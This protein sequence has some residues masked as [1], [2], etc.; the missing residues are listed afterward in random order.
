MEPGQS[1]SLNNNNHNKS[2]P[3]AEP[4]YLFYSK[5]KVSKQPSLS[6]K[7]EG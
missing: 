4:V 5:T 6:R 3:Q 1:K 2:I 7:V